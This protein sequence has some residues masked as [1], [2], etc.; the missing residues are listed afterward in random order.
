MTFVW[1][2]DWLDDVHEPC[3]FCGEAGVFVDGA[4]GPYVISC[5][6]PA[7]PISG[8]EVLMAVWDNRHASQHISCSDLLDETSSVLRKANAR[9]ELI[10]QMKA[11]L[12]RQAAEIG[13]LYRQLHPDTETPS[14]ESDKET[15]TNCAEQT[16]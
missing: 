9:L 6:N 16:Q 10:V 15:P 8:V 13:M 5:T 1:D 12:A 2:S 3:P 11:R 7:C 4:D 14:A